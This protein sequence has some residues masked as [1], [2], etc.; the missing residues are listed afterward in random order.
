MG[1]VWRH[2]KV[3]HPKTPC[4]S[5]CPGRIFLGWMETTVAGDLHIPPGPQ[6]PSTA[7]LAAI[8]FHLLVTSPQKGAHLPPKPY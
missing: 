8:E 4:G 3:T 2:P 6:A 7:W 5:W 1:R